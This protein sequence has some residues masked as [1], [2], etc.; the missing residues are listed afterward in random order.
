MRSF[1]QAT[2]SMF[3]SLMIVLLLTVGCPK[4]AAD[5]RI[6]SDDACHECTEFDHLTTHGRVQVNCRMVWCYCRYFDAN[7][8]P[9][10][11]WCEPVEQSTARP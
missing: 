5:K 3:I 11:L 8:G 10:T 2:S 1:R 4:K 7:G 9:A 6:P